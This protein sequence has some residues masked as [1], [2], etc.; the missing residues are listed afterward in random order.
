MTPS[1][2]GSPALFG[3]PRLATSFVGTALL[4]LALPLKISAAGASW[5][6]TRLGVISAVSSVAGL[7]VLLV[8][9]R[10]SD[11]HR[12]RLGRKR[13]PLM[14]LALAV[15]PLALFAMAE[16]DLT[17]LLASVGLVAARSMVDG[18][19]LP[20][21]SEASGHAQVPRFTGFITFFQLLGAAF[22]ALAFGAGW[23]L[24][25]LGIVLVAASIA[26]FASAGH[27]MPWPRD[28]TADAPP[29]AWP[30]EVVYLLAARTL[31]MAAVFIVTT[32]LLYVVR[33]V[34]AV[35]DFKRTTAMFYGVALTGALIAVLPMARL[36]TRAGDKPVLFGA[37]ATIGAAVI[38]L[39]VFGPASRT[40]AV[41]CMFFYGVALAAL[42]TSGLA[43][44]QRVVPSPLVAGRVLAAATGTAFLSQAIASLT[45]ALLVDP[46][47]AIE[48]RFGYY[49]LVAALEVLILAGGACLLKVRVPL[50]ALRGD[51][52]SLR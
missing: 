21:L 40:L 22:G 42:G 35:A 26:G 11:R 2:L 24:P 50:V 17:L 46:L 37:G 4:T 33:D 39:V 44:M 32:F 29:S 31:F 30:V 1:R 52:S 38:V 48:P 28:E 34:L 49:A 13:Y 16:D 12:L 27:K 9:G 47:N 23:P 20:V 41:A 19:H 43:L 25:A 18:S 45:G 36:S 15:P 14:G 10:Y 7:V 6:S 51:G 3:L 5:Q 8:V